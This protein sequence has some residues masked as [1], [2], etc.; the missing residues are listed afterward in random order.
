[1]LTT[2]HAVCFIRGSLSRAGFYACL[3]LASVRRPV[4]LVRSVARRPPELRPPSH[5]SHDFFKEF[6]R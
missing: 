6:D 4:K 5:F 3:R 1:M 2:W